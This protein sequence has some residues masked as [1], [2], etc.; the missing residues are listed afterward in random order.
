M[1]K[2]LAVFAVALI[3]SGAMAQVDPDPD[4][5]GVYF[6]V[7]GLTYETATAAPFQQ[8]TAYLLITNP[9]APAGVSGWE[10]VVDVT[11]GAVGASWVLAAGLNVTTAPIFQVGIGLGAAALPAA[12]AVL[13]ATWSGFIMAPTDVVGFVITP[14]NVSF[15]DS[16]GYAAGDDETDLIGLQVSN[17]FP[18]GD[19]CALI[20]ST[21]V[22][23]NEDLTFSNVKNMFQ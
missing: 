7:A 18:Y 10:A 5:I 6:D 21:G 16:P 19:A 12:P 17:G 15:A 22:V 8:V 1:K 20:N 9:T 2:L 11:G 14:A 13:L 23:A 3:A 4:G